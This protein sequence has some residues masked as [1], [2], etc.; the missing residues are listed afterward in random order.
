[1]A[2]ESS[3]VAAGLASSQEQ[4]EALLRKLYPNG[5]ETGRVLFTGPD[6]VRDHKV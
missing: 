2:S 5:R 6:G 3:V 1:M 4:K